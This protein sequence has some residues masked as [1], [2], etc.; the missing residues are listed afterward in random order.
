[1]KTGHHLNHHHDVQR[2]EK[3]RRRR[4]ASVVLGSFAMLL[5]LLAPL[6]ATGSL[7]Q[8]SVGKSQN[9]LLPSH[10]APPHWHA[11]C[12]EEFGRRPSTCSH[13]GVATMPLFV[14]LLSPSL[15]LTLTP[16]AEQGCS[17]ATSQKLLE[18]VQ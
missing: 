9:G 3:K 5:M 11:C 2:R 15:L 7:K 6:S 17:A 16:T 10:V 1:M 4:S 8:V 18:L 13:A 14:L 12:W